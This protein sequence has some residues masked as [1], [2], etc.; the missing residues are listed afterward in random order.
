MILRDLFIE[1]EDV[2]IIARAIFEDKTTPGDVDFW[3]R[4]YYAQLRKLKMSKV[5]KSNMMF[6]F[7]V[8]RNEERLYGCV[9]GFDYE[10]IKAGYEIYYAIEGLE[11]KKYASLYVPEYTVQRYR[12]EVVAAEAL[13]EYGWN[14]F[15]KTIVCPDNVRTKIHASLEMMKSGIFPTDKD[16]FSRCRKQF[17]CAFEGKPV[18]LWEE[19]K[20][21]LGVLEEEQ[22]IEHVV[23]I[24]F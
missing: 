24:S 15:D 14:G 18:P 11:Y 4:K 8:N 10:D 22:I 9:S 2:Q 20:L 5:H 7:S 13:R 21:A 6:Y 3:I 19:D 1:T 23:P 17:V 12:K 16:Y